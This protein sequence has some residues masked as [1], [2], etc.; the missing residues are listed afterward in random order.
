MGSNKEERENSLKCIILAV[1]HTDGDDLYKSNTLLVTKLD[2]VRRM[3]S[4]FPEIDK[5]H[6]FSILKKRGIETDFQL[7]TSEGQMGVYSKSYLEPLYLELLMRRHALG[8]KV[9]NVER[10]Y[11]AI[12]KSYEYNEHPEKVVLLRAVRFSK[13]YST[14]IETVKWGG[15]K[16]EV[17][18]YFLHRTKKCDDPPQDQINC[19]KVGDAVGI[20]EYGDGA[21]FEYGR[22]G[23]TRDAH[24]DQRTKD[25]EKIATFL[26][27]RMRRTSG[28]APWMADEIK[29]LD[30]HEYA[31][32]IVA[33]TESGP[34]PA[35]RVANYLEPMLRN[36]KFFER[37]YRLYHLAIITGYEP[38]G[39][40]NQVPEGAVLRGYTDPG[41][42]DRCRICHVWVA[43]DNLVSC[44]NNGCLICSLCSKQF[45]GFG[46]DCFHQY[47]CPLCEVFP[48]KL[49]TYVEAMRNDTTKKI[50]DAPEEGFPFPVNIGGQPSKVEQKVKKGQLQSKNHQLIAPNQNQGVILSVRQMK[51]MHN[52]DAQFSCKVTSVDLGSLLNPIYFKLHVQKVGDKSQLD[53]THF[54][55]PNPAAL[56]L[57]RNF[58]N[59]LKNGIISRP[60]EFVSEDDVPGAMDNS[61]VEWGRG[62]VFR[63][64]DLPD[65]ARFKRPIPT[66]PNK[67]Q[68][69]A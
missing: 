32:P 40:I 55:D 30:P 46:D 8:N 7:R 47:K 36:A 12:Q 14:T 56:S 65:G 11:S 66:N 48:G 16:Q 20:C 27:G 58:E 1:E 43:K 26:G 64:G 13:S 44:T 35:Q 69:T 4:N 10:L 23:V 45:G 15:S 2:D 3:M 68:R 28:K 67:K 60:N 57:I 61:R 33:E 24:P 19:G 17:I 25:E 63:R 41:S 29:M 52:I 39:N 21:Y 42:Y 6:P 62:H 51:Q 49:K 18:Y 37:D 54:F 38:R 31:R 5:G 22:P 59:N 53:V 50:T 9:K 34:P